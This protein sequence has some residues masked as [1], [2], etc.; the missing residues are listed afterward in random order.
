MIRSA[1]LLLVLVSNLLAQAP[2]AKSP[3]V[4]VIHGGAGAI[5]RARMTP[6]QEKA[7]RQGL[8]RA[9]TAGYEVLEKGGS[10]LDAV[11]TAVR[12]LEDDPLFNA[13]K[14]AVLTAEGKAELDAAI[15]D[16]RTLAAGSV[17]GLTRIKNPVTLAR[18][19]MTQSPHVMMVGTGAEA[20]AKTQG[21]AFVAN[22]YF[23]TPG[24]L[25]AWKKLKK[26]KAPGST[27]GT[28]GAVAL[29]AQ[30]NLA[31]AT[32]TGGMM[33]KRFG[34]V[35]DAPLIGIGTYADNGTCAISCTGWGEFF[36]RVVVAHDIAAQMRYRG[37]PLA[38]AARRTLDKVRALGGDGGLIALD[39]K[40]NLTVPFNT[41]GMFRAFRHSDGR[42][43][44][45]IF[46]E[47]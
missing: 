29:D 46:A 16:G 2:E 39:A 25:E 42:T 18:R 13:G 30:G 32:S 28:V 34:R 15:M 14:G 10:S 37:T 1:C 12:V 20:F 38:E 7:Y 26:E 8:E 19:V 3:Q 23:L 35:G 6:D 41:Q 24:R 33:N 44:I 45:A 17:A 40:G 4:L 36:I 22:A 9:L 43:E 11:E 21:L 27:K 47:E 5:A 31:A